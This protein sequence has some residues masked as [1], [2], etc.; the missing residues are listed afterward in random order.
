MGLTGGIGSGKSAVSARL[1]EHGAVVVDADKLARDVV[2]PG[3]PGLTA[4]AEAFGPGVLRP[5]G[6]LDRA[7]LGQIVFADPAARRR[8][9]GITHPLIRDET[10]RRFAAP[11][12]D[13]VVV[14]DIPLLVEAGMGKGY[15]LVVV[16]EAPRELRL[17][18]LAGRGLPRDQAEARMATQAD[19][20][21]RRAVADVLLD[22]SGT[23]AGLHAQVDALWHDLVAR[24]DAQP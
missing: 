10:A 1:A 20:A 12:P 7:A 5:D 22:N 18:R 6:S 24:R 23:L 13:A 15:D 2:A 11:P 9:E 3:T 17:E 21:A 16:V 19:D 4:V 14:H 8:L